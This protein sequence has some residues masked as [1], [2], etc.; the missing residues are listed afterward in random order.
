M[1]LMLFIHIIGGTLT[2]FAGAAALVFKKGSRPHKLSGK[3]FTW[4]M[5]ISLFA[6]M[7]PALFKNN[8]FL[9]MIA[10]FSLFM[11][12]SGN[13][14]LYF[15]HDKNRQPKPLDY[16][17]NGLNFLVCTGGIILCIFE[18]NIPGMV[19][20]GFGAAFSILE[21]RQYSAIRSGKMTPK[22]WLAKHISMMCGAYISAVTA[23][24]VVN[25][26]AKFG[27]IVWFIPTIIGSPLIAYFTARFTKSTKNIAP[28]LTAAAIIAGISFLKITPLSAQPYVENDTSRFRF[29]Q[30]TL[31]TEIQHI[32]GGE[33]FPRIVIGGTHFWGHADFMV[34][35]PVARIGVTDGMSFSSGIETGAKFF[36]W[37]IEKGKIRPFIG[38]DWAVG[39]VVL[40]ENTAE[41]PEFTKHILSPNA[42]VFIDSDWGM[43]TFGA[44]YNPLK[45]VEY[46]LADG[47]L[48]NYGL[49]QMNFR[50][51]YRR[52]FETTQGAEELHT[53]GQ[54]KIV[55]EKL[56]ESG[57]LNNLFFGAG[58]SSAFILGQAH[59]L[60]NS[61]YKFIVSPAP[62]PEFSVGYYHHELDAAVNIN[63]R[64]IA[65]SQTTY[66]AEQR[67]S[68]RVFALEVIKFVGDY[69]GFVPFLGAAIGCEEISYSE[70][71]D[72][73][74]EWRWNP[75]LVLGWDIR[76]NRIQFFT[77]RTNLRWTPQKKFM[78]GFKEIPL[79]Q[80]EVNF[81]ELILY[82]GRIF[83]WD[84]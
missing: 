15:L 78:N 52:S 22:L 9:F 13:R 20:G 63:F 81:F 39:N 25:F 48:K 29:A 68:R 54:E 5:A 83:R 31:G 59:F 60:K 40:K 33:T 70:E 80:L 8:L 26:T 73:L 38:F 58:F 55:V 30:L 11:L 66:N 17:I 41:N 23:F 32:P 24:L 67:W 74:K 49:P 71:D 46:P 34:S 56:A 51:G 3:I 1:K 7:I 4:S 50:I 28:K 45:N 72:L 57:R 42:G 6:S 19:F 27:I 64:S 82:P 43:F 75:S 61:A 12:W 65:H 76:P 53:S 77:I 62:F 44:S 16:I 10:V 36:P 84:I 21:I 79:D 47:I 18:K 35:I 69:H 37:R 14:A 2:L